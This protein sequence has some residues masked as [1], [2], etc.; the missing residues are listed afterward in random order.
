[1]RANSDWLPAWA[2]QA[3]WHQIFSER[4]HNGNSR[5]NP[6]LADIDGALPHDQA[7]PWRIHPWTSEWYELQP[8]EAANGQAF[9][10]NAVR[11]R[12]DDHPQP[13]VEPLGKA[14]GRTCL[15]R[16]TISRPSPVQLRAKSRRIGAL[17][18]RESA[19]ANRLACVGSQ[20][21]RED[22]G[23]HARRPGRRTHIER[24]SYLRYQGPADAHRSPGIRR[25]LFQPDQIS[26]R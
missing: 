16:A 7:S 12:S 22:S 6:T 26:Q 2:R 19:C 5:A 1:M 15:S 24:R 8:Y 20:S 21:D 14:P 25:T 3:I 23:W 11:R 18:W 17:S 10:Y 9:V 4:F 13:V